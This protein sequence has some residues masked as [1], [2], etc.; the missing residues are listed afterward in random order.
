VACSGASRTAPGGGD[1]AG[2]MTE[3][4]KQASTP[5]AALDP[6]EAVEDLLRSLK[7]HTEGLSSREAQRRL[8]QYGPNQLQRLGGV[9]WPRELARQLTHPL[10]LLLWVAALLSFIVGSITV[11]VAVVLIIVLNAAVAFVQERHAENAVEALAGYIP[12]KLTVVR[13]GTRR[14]IDTAELVPGDI[15]LVE[16]GERIAA[17]MR[18]ISGAVE[19]DLSTL[20]GESVPA[21]RSAEYHDRDRPRLEARELLFS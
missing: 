3:T 6:T 19:V 8:A 7:T 10:A 9:K 13:D 15:A 16:E 18:L 1:E 2:A 20:T 12:Q 5:A 11:G 14:V 17:D 4:I 21:M